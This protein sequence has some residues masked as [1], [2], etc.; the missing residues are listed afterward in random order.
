MK[1][2]TTANQFQVILVFQNPSLKK[3]AE[4]RVCG[5]LLGI[6]YNPRIH[7][8]MQVVTQKRHR[9]AP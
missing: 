5:A 4:W 9:R 7:H 1:T 3:R 6:A 8:Y 2:Y